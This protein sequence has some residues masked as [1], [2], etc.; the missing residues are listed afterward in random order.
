LADVVGSSQ[1]PEVTRVEQIA[2]GPGGAILAIL[3]QVG[4]A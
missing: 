4:A 1:P 3:G 2:L